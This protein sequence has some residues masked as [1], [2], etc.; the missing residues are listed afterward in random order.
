MRHTIQAMKSITIEETDRL[1]TE[2]MSTP[3][4]S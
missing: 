2:A 1:G 3:G 4:K